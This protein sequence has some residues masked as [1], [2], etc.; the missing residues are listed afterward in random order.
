MIDLGDCVEVLELLTHHQVDIGALALGVEL[1]AVGDVGDPNPRFVRF[2]ATSCPRP[3]RPE[4]SMTLIVTS[5]S[6]RIEISTDRQSDGVGEGV[7]WVPV[8]PPTLMAPA[9]CHELRPT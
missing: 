5:S 8:P 3:S 4:R 1:A 9:L 6:L 7:E 2:P